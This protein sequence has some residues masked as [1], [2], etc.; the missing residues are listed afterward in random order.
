MNV[1]VRRIQQ[2][3]KFREEAN[4]LFA[5]QLF[6]PALNRYRKGIN[7][8]DKWPK[9]IESDSKCIKAKKEFYV[10][11]CGNSAQ[12]YM[13]LGMYKEAVTILQDIVNQTRNSVRARL[14]RNTK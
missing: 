6:D 4:A 2:L 7:F 1:M 10:I 8:L 13:E 9:H 14:F 11:F 12:C 3:N 5:K